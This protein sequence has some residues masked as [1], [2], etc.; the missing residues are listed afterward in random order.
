MGFQTLAMRYEVDGH[1]ERGTASHQ[2][3]MNDVKSGPRSL[4]IYQP[5]AY[6]NEAAGF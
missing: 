6:V 2:P 1:G 5:A 3:P 4:V